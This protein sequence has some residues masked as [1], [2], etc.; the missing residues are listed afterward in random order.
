VTFLITLTRETVRNVILNVSIV[1]RICA[2]V[3]RELTSIGVSPEFPG[4]N[5]PLPEHSEEEGST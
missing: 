5:E 4:S 1:D 2:F 3:M